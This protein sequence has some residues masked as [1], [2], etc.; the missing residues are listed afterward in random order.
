MKFNIKLNGVTVSKNIPATW[1][2]VTWLHFLKLSK[3]GGDISEII[4]VFT[5]I[6][7]AT[8]KSAQ[9]KNFDTLVSCLNFL[10]KPMNIIV[11][12]VIQGLRVPMNI[13]DEAAARYGDLQEITEK[14]KPDDKTGNLEYYPLIVATY[15]TPSPYNFKEAE[16]LAERLKT[17]S[18]VEVLA[19]GNFILTRYQKARSGTMNNSPKGDTIATRLRQA[20]RHWLNRLGF[21]ILYIFWKK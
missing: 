12:S 2:E 10:Q 14:F 20:I 1:H 17:A 6:D 9:I 3:A 16:Q 21:S 7:A 4:S 13:E 18:S 19:T 15:L 11:P 5:D 8:I